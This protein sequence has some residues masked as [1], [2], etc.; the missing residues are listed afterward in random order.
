MRA[1]D[2]S[3]LVTGY[4]RRMASRLPLPLVAAIAVL[5]LGFLPSAVMA[6]RVRPLFEP[7]DLELEQPGTLELDVQLGV[8]RGEQAA[9]VVVPDFELDVGLLPFLELDL[10]GAYAIEGPTRGPFAFDHAAPDSLWSAAKL[11]F[12][13]GR[14]VAAHTALALGIQLGPKWPIAPAAHGVGVEALLLACTT[15]RTLQLV[16]NAG[17]FVEPAPERVLAARPNGVE[18]GVD[19]S[20]ALDDAQ[21]FS[22]IGSVSFVHFRSQD[23]DQL[24]G[25]AGVAWSVSDMLDL[26][27]VGLIGVLS[28]GD[29]Y[30]ALLGV[31]PK[32][33]V[34]D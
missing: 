8:V 22:A 9:R 34:L 13:D 15:Y 6:R 7:T 33:R 2:R 16:W 21:R 11:G 1:I 19:A 31:A 12:Y 24:L 29:H 32:L 25:V 26:S 23:A 28:G 4:N 10:D 30:G 17:G 5:G 3:A 27:L 18:L 20:V 14:N